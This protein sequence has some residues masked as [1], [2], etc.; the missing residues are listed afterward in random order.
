MNAQGA[1]PPGPIAP[2]RRRL[3]AA[4]AAWPVLTAGS[5]LLAG[6]VQAAPPPAAA[7]VQVGQRLRDATM[8]GLNGPS[9]ALSSYRGRPLLINVWASWCPPCR[10]EMPS[11]ER[12]AWSDFGQQMAVIGI[13]TD[14]YVDRALAFLRR[15]NATLSHYIDR[16]LELEHMLGASHL[17]LTVLADAQGRVLLKVSG[18][19]EWDSP[20]SR[21]LI[22][23]HLRLGRAVPAPG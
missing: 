20:G 3:I 14:D 22:E 19:R 21:Q 18:A 13:S 1:L 16:Q 5:P 15:S 7:A 8:R 6:S 17:P 12:L 4:A 10:A 9:R 23:R 2:G 11:L